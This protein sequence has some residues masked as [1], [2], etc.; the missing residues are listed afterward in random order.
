MPSTYGRRHGLPGYDDFR[1][2]VDFATAQRMLW[3]TS[4]DPRDWRQKSRGCVLGLM[5]ELKLAL[6]HEMVDRAGGRAPVRKRISHRGRRFVVTYWVN[7]ER[8]TSTPP[9]DRIPVRRQ[10][11]NRGRSMTVT[12]WTKPKAKEGLAA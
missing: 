11:I 10:I 2:G 7:V 8:K 4:D 5:H 1:S 12:Y 6:Y 3:S 9:P